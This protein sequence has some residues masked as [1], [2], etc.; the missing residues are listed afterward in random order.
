[1]NRNALNAA[2]PG[3]ALAGVGGLHGAAVYSE[4]LNPEWQSLASAMLQH[5]AGGSDATRAALA[6][7]GQMQDEE[8]EVQDNPRPTKRGKNNQNGATADYAMR[9][10]AAEQRR[11]ARINER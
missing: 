11:R 9:H 7:L 4:S 10:Q 2:L 8:D 6:A 3:G 1:M 5:A